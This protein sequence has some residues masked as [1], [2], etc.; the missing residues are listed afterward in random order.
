MTFQA[1]LFWIILSYLLGSLVT[2]LIVYPPRTRNLI[3][4]KYRPA[5]PVRCELRKCEKCKGDEPCLHDDHSQRYLCVRCHSTPEDHFF[6][7]RA[8]VLSTTR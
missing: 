7:A 1:F 8:T 6:R 2:F 3:P 4:R 5:R